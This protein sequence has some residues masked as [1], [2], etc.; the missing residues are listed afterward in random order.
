[1]ETPDR[2]SHPADRRPPR[3]RAAS[4]RAES[5]P[6]KT[7][8]VELLRVRH[9]MQA[10]ICL[11]DKGPLSR[12]ELCWQLGQSTTT[13]TKV[14]GELL[15][16]GWVT[17]GGPRPS[18]D[19]G[20]PRT[21][22]LLAPGAS[23]ILV[24]SVEPDRIGS[25][26]VGLDLVP[27]DTVSRDF[28]GGIGAG[29]DAVAR[30]V[31]VAASETARH[32]ARGRRIDGIAIVAPG[33][34]DTDL[35]V[36]RYAQQLGWRH[37]DIAGPVE[38]RTGLPAI[39]CNNTRC[40]ALAEFRQLR[41]ASGTPMLFVQA[42]YGLGA[43]LVD[44]VAP[45]AAAHLGASELGQIPLGVNGFADRVPAD[46]QLMS[47]LKEAYLRAVLRDDDTAPVVRRLE[48]ARTT[49]DGARLYAQTV[50]NLAAAIG[51]AVNLLNPSVV[52]VGGIYAEG[53]DAFLADL[54]G[55]LDAHAEPELLAGMR[56][57]RTVRGAAGAFEG[58]ALLAFDRL[59]RRPATYQPSAAAA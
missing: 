22:L 38:A 2:A 27:Q 13:M 48:A 56:V 33:M 34:T 28:A 1:M 26:R 8:P 7:T 51:V 5:G 53:S 10:L 32:A 54:R 30:I 36:S 58:G 44:S 45:G 43:A 47:V 49:P 9:R 17:E 23:N 25:A 24:L 35:R 29:A 12:V 3:A 55:R 42:R 37:L 52:V 21:T 16:L 40:M 59:L 41:L 6:G 20:R 19:V 15:A 57:Q 11:R 14:V 4:R 50:D 46:R 31:S 18:R 39:L